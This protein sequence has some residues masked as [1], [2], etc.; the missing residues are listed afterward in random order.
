M[1][2]TSFSE[3]DRATFDSLNSGWHKR[4]IMIGRAEDP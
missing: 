2:G 3:S 4:E 1:A